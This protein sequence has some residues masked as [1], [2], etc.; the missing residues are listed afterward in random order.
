MARIIAPFKIEGTLH[1]TNF[2]VDQD[3]INRAR[4]KAASSMTSEKY[5]TLPIYHNVRMQSV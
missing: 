3:N 2:Y 5:W 4:E 1:D